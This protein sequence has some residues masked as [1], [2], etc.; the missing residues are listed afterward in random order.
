VFFFLNRRV[1]YSLKILEFLFVEVTK[2]AP[3]DADYSKERAYPL[4]IWTRFRWRNSFSGQ[5]E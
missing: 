5:V 3:H 4:A 2:T 1:K